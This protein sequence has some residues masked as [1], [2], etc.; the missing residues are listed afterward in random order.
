M[1]SIYDVPYED[2]KKFL[3][4]NNE[5]FNNKDDAYNKATVLLK[6]KKSKGHTV[7]IIEWMMAHNLLIHNVNIPNYTIY[8]ID[9]MSQNE[10]NHL[11]KLLKMKSNN[12]D[13]VKNI[14]FYLHKLDDKILLPEINEIILLNLTNLE[15][16]EIESGALDLN[17]VI[18]LL[19]THH[20]K[21][22]IRKALYDNMEKIIFY[23]FLDV[24]YNK[25][26]D[27]LYIDSLRYNLPKS[28]T[29]KLVKNNENRL[30]KNNTPEEINIILDLLR[31]ND[32]SEGV[33]IGEDI[34]TFTNFLID[35]IKIDEIGLAK[36]VFD[37]ATK[38]EFTGLITHNKYSLNKY[39]VQELIYH[40]ENDIKT[41]NTLLGFIGETQFIINLGDVFR[42]TTLR[43]KPNYVKELLNKLVLLEKYNLVEIVVNRLATFNYEGGGDV[44]RLLL[45]LLKKA[46]ELKNYDLVTKYLKI[47]DLTINKKLK[48]NSYRLLNIDDIMML[49]QI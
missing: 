36:Q 3:L 29:L 45:P 30:L 8:E 38:Y 7:S 1:T 32:Y 14:L 47:V 18:N 16:N 42:Y 24:D 37:I 6:N 22:L 43:L 27:L 2:I 40:P 11:S 21:A 15:I 17:Y 46:I 12:I 49:N 23:N 10:I 19:K 26:D 13:N 33:N 5:K 31:Q 28:I 41:L 4:S 35:L 9:N 44:Y 34:K 39:L 25:L 20:N 48:T